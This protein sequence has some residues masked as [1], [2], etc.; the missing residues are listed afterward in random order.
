M[1]ARGTRLERVFGRSLTVKTNGVEPPAAAAFPARGGMRTSATEAPRESGDLWDDEGGRGG[2]ARARTEVI[3]RVCWRGA[4]AD[5]T[6]A[7]HFVLQKHFLRKGEVLSCE[8]KL[9]LVLSRRG[10][11]EQIGPG[12]F[13]K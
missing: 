11:A 13:Q 4:A 3:T 12:L 6:L 2:H 9:C 8:T 1:Q 10:L 7:E 5:H